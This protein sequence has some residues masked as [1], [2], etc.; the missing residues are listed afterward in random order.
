MEDEALELHLALLG[1]F[2]AGIHH[3]GLL[4]QP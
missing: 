4:P 2:V 3:S 1:D